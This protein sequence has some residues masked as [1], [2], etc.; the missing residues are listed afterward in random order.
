MK[1]KAQ[2]GMVMNLDKCIGCHTCSV[3]C[4]NTWTNRS[5]AEYMYFNN[6]E[7][8]PGIGYPKQWENQD[9]YKGGWELKKG[10]LQLKSG[11]KATR[12]MNLFYNPYQPTIDDYYEPWNYDYETLTNSP[13][14]K[15][16]PVARPK[17]SI[18]GDFMN[19]EWGPNWED[20]LAGG[21]ITGL[22]DP[23]VKKMEESIKTEFEDV[24]MMYLP[25]ICEHCINPSCVSSCPSGAMY[26]RE[27]DGIV[28]V[29]QNACR[30]W[31]HCVS[32]CPYKKV[33]FNWQTNKAE[34]CTLCFPRLEAGLPTICSETCVGR[35][36]YL[37]V[38][39][40]D[41]EK[42]EEAASAENEKDLYHSQLEI[43][44]DPNDPAVAEEAKAQGIPLEWI[45]AA[46]KSP[47]YKMIID[48]K[49]ALPLHPE[50]RTL[51]MV[52]YIPPL[53]PI[54]NMFEGKGT[55]QSAEDIFPAIDEM[56]I[57]IEYLANLLTAGDTHHI[58]TTLKKMSVMRMHMRA[59]QT[60]K[61]IDS[62]LIQDTGLTE[63]QIEDMYR[64]LAIAKY[65]DRFVIPQTHREE[66]A[67]LYMEQGSC[68]LSFAGGPG[69]CQNI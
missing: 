56:R 28:L 68:G 63:E 33:Y 22:Q 15:H 69:S 14:K 61:Q 51:P 47:I 50:Y 4:K 34:K 18:T 49:I 66:V 17:S 54:M 8:K 2:I 26:K 60:N 11:A 57:P 42:V 64:L 46:Q 38:M 48:W 13:E 62:S 29:D 40:Y 37:G 3:T 9:K 16:Q 53:S 58:R 30:S 35:I 5:G 55:A 44:L 24:F 21:H 32:S 10:K 27:E 43:F 39:L 19:L 59:T 52:W 6:V 31:R 23:N 65:D 41:A 1:I 36:R 20:D 7:T 25:R 12:L 45:E 67:D